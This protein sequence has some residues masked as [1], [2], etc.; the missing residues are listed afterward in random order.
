MIV[1]DSRLRALNR[2]LRRVEGDDV[3]RV[4]DAI[5]RHRRLLEDQQNEA[6]YPTTFAVPRDESDEPGLPTGRST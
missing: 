2:L 5:R 6:S 3:A 4:Q 1:M